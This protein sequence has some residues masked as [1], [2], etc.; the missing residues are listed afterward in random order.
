MGGVTLF[1]IIIEGKKEINREEVGT[2]SVLVEGL[3]GVSSMD[4]FSSS[5]HARSATESKKGGD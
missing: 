4:C 3:E 1:S 5:A 2:F